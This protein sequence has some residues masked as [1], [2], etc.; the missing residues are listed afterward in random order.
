[1]DNV[2]KLFRLVAEQRQYKFIENI[3]LRGLGLLQKPGVEKCLGR[4]YLRFTFTPM[5]FLRRYYQVIVRELATDN[6]NKP[7]PLEE[8]D[9]FKPKDLYTYDEARRKKPDLVPYIAAQFP[10]GEF[11]RYENFVVGAGSKGSSEAKRKR[12]R[13]RVEGDSQE[14]YNGP[15]EEKTYYAVFQR[16]YVSEVSSVAH[17]CQVV[18]WACP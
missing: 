12:R 4:W 7:V 15:L 10:A 5:L 8:P 14:Y 3:T 18:P 11:D 6:R 13:R 9:S 17:R 16:A 1:M 2:I